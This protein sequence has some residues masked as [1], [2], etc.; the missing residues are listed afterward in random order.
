MP[1]CCAAAR[2][3]MKPQ[4]PE[5]N[6]ERGRV[7]SF[8]P[9]IPRARSDNDPRPWPSRSPAEDLG[10][11]VFSQYKREREAEDHRHRMTNNLLAL[12]VLC[13]IVSCGIWLT[14]TMAEMTAGFDCALTGR[15][16]CA[17]IRLP[18]VEPR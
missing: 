14:N 12:A 16:N 2:P 18:P 15:T 1:R 6:E 11:D 7:V 17:P 4:G 3:G 10:K 5:R 8:R 13:V 9:R